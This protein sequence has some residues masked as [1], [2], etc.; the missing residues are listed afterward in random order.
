MLPHGVGVGRS[1]DWQAYQGATMLH[2]NLRPGTTFVAA[3][4]EIRAWSW[5]D[6]APARGTVIDLEGQPPAGGRRSIADVWGA[7]AAECAA[8]YP[9]DPSEGRC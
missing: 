3:L 8:P 2:D 5:G 1:L 7:T 9:C 6:D 4:G